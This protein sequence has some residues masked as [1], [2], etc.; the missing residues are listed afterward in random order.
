MTTLPEK[1]LL[2]GKKVPRT[3][4]GEMK[5]ALGNLR[6]FLAELFGTDSSDK[7]AARKTLGI[8]LTELTNK[9]DTKTDQDVFQS[10]IQ[11]K[12]DKT[13]L[14]NR[15]AELEQEI[16]KRGAPVGTI[17]YFAMAIPPAGYLLANGAE[18]GRSTYPDL[19]DAIGTTFGEGDGETTFNL[20]DLIGRF[21]QGSL[22]PGQEILA[23]LP[24]IEGEWQPFAS[25]ASAIGTR[26]SDYSGA[27]YP[28]MT[29]GGY[30]ASGGQDSGNSSRGGFRASLSNPVYGASA[31]VQPPALTLLPC[32]KGFD[33]V[34]VPGLIDMTGLANDVE[35]LSDTVN[36][37]LDTMVDEKPVRYVTDAYSDGANW[38]RKWSDGW[39]E[40][41]GNVAQGGSGL[42]TVNLIR[43]FADTYTLTVTA[44]ALSD[45]S[46]WA[47]ATNKTVTSFQVGTKN[48]VGTYTFY[49]VD[50]Y[51]SGQGI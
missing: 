10:V 34:T 8:D 13:D 25:W 44:S 14:E 23:G 50:W 48:Y 18:V 36:G 16:A 45:T 4:T 5:T 35:R 33:A 27:F 41:G 21:P 26:A 32:I 29:S 7:E 39:L 15:M 40:Q 42:K 37:K 17:E 3:T 28:V 11:G 46:Y 31:T 43:P 2:S 6:D 20:P 1:D 24:D 22:V 30:P 12:A 9:I 49:A 19:F 47:S 51:A 38:W